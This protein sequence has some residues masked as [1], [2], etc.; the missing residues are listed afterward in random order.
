MRLFSRDRPKS[1]VAM[2]YVRN[3]PGDGVVDWDVRR[4]MAQYVKH[5]SWKVEAIFYDPDAQRSPLERR[6][7]WCLLG[8][9]ASAPVD[10]VVVATRRALSDDPFEAA[11]AIRK[12]ESEGNCRVV[13][14]AET[15][16][17]RALTGRPPQRSD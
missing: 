11:G 5:Q 9:I 10:V 14:F 17:E 4:R 8:S 15:A 2:E 1:L 13:I 6:I 16:E 3:R 7:F 12:I